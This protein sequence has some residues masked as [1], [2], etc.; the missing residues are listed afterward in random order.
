MSKRRRG[1]DTCCARCSKLKKC[2]EHPAKHRNPCLHQPG[3]ES[4]LCEQNGRGKFCTVCRD[5]AG[6]PREDKNQAKMFRG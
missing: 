5:F 2:R 1:S 4:C 3:D 6:Q